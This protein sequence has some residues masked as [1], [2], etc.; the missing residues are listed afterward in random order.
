LPVA[1]AR[2]DVALPQAQL[3]QVQSRIQ[4]TGY[5]LEIW[6]PA[7]VFVGFDP[8]TN[9]RIGFHYVVHDTERGDQA[10]AVGSEFPVES[11][12]SLWQT[13]ELKS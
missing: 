3:V 6:F 2:E 11:D 9:A 13:V 7:E 5:D 4:P 1:R 12:P 10:L 8:A